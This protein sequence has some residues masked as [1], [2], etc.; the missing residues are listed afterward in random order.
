MGFADICSQ[1]KFLADASK[2]SAA[3]DRAHRSRL[4]DSLWSGRVLLLDMMSWHSIG[5][6][7]DYVYNSLILCSPPLPSLAACAHVLRSLS[8]CFTCLDLS[9]LLLKAVGWA[10]SASLPRGRSVDGMKASSGGSWSVERPSPWH[11]GI[12]TSA[13]MAAAG[14]ILPS[15]AK[16]GSFASSSSSVREVGAGRGGGSASS[17]FKENR[18]RLDAAMAT[19]AFASGGGMRR[20]DSGA[21]STPGGTSWTVGLGRERGGGN[22][23]GVGNGGGGS[24]EI[25]PASSTSSSGGGGVGMAV[26]AEAAAAARRRGSGGKWSSAVDGGSSASGGVSRRYANGGERPRGAS[27]SPSRRP[28]PTLPPPA[29]QELIPP[30]ATRPLGDAIASSSASTPSTHFDPL[31]DMLTDMGF[32]RAEAIRALRFSDGVVERAAELLLTPNDFDTSN[33]GIGIH[34]GTDTSGAVGEPGDANV[35]Y[36][37]HRKPGD[38]GNG[39]IAWG[40]GKELQVISVK[41]ARKHGGER[42]EDEDDLITN[43]D[44]GDVGQGLDLGEFWASHQKGYG[45]SV[46]SAAEAATTLIASRGG[47]I[48]KMGVSFGKHEHAIH[49][50]EQMEEEDEDRDLVTRYEALVI[51]LRVDAHVVFAT[52][53]GPIGQGSQ[54]VF[55]G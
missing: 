39:N 37:P 16:K 36:G 28:P 29:L 4:S 52:R 27:S 35:V 10:D 26:A 11:A 33:I 47:S 53:M 51:T 1:Y 31:V 21:R 19:T 3:G 9:D 5:V 50:R 15:S 41:D 54:S 38:N 42:D 23:G 6:R 7:M 48:W 18:A 20:A 12:S 45:S 17:T 25:W 55:C 13:A 43:A 46:T 8:W 34:D 40:G 32:G 22:A 30:P 14:A 24:A 44:A 2:A 49:D